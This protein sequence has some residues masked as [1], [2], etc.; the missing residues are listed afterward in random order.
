MNI[1]YHGVDKN[2]DDGYEDGMRSEE[3]KPA[4]KCLINIICSATGR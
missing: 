2:N 1:R 3:N 4:M